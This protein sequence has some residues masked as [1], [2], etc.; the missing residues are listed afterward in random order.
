MQQICML[1]S[2]CHHWVTTSHGSQVETQK[3]PNHEEHPGLNV[4]RFL[5]RGGN[6]LKVEFGAVL[7]LHSQ[8]KPC[9]LLCGDSPPKGGQVTDRAKRKTEQ[10]RILEKKNRVKM[11]FVG[12]FYP[13]TSCPWQQWAECQFA[14]H[15]RRQ[16]TS[17]QRN[18]DTERSDPWG[19]SLL[20]ASS[21]SF[22]SD[23]YPR[24]CALSSLR[25]A[26]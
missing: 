8:H 9:L 4:W 17:M 24:P 22:R 26:A 2:L 21:S 7:F 18:V 12:E 5:S 20:H 14:V 19:E 10:C 25:A 16:D 3:T 15:H 1:C 6:A 23:L 13:C 11:F